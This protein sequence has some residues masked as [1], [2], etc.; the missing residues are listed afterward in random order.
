MRSWCPVWRSPP[1]NRN[2]GLE[3]LVDDVDAVYA[4]LL[5]LGVEMVKPPTTQPWSNRSFYFRDPEGNLLN[6]Y[7]RTAVS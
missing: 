7:S 6:F 1:T 3:F 2:L 5:E 4:R